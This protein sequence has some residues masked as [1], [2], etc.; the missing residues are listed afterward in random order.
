MKCK[1]LKKQHT[2]I[3][4]RN[5]SSANSFAGDASH[6]YIVSDREYTVYSLTLATYVFICSQGGKLYLHREN[7]LRA[8]KK[9]CIFAP[10]RRSKK[11]IL[12]QHWREEKI[13]KGIITI[14][15]APS[16]LTFS[17]LSSILGRYDTRRV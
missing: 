15:V 5:A 3:E 6:I 13:K 4:M 7:N 16:H 2:Y 12:T 11:A 17:S 10:K 1:T 14:K 9:D 8:Q